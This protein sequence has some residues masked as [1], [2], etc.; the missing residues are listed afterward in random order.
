MAAAPPPFTPNSS[1][2]RDIDFGVISEAF[3]LLTANWQTY[4]TAGG[5]S[6]LALLPSVVVAYLPMIQ[7][8]MGGKPDPTAVFATLGLQLV[9][10]F[11]GVL[12]A[13]FISVGVVKHTLN[14]TRGLPAS[15]G[16]IFEGFRDPL[17]YFAVMFLAG[18]VG[19]L[20]VIA[21]CIGALFTAGLVMFALPHKVATGET[22][23][24]SI[25]KSWEMLKSNWPMAGIFLLVVS[26]IAQ[27]G[28]I[29]CYIGLVFTM[30]FQYIATTLLYNR[31]VGW[32]PQVMYNPASPYPR[33]QG[34]GYD[35]GAGAPPSE[36]P[37]EPPKPSDMG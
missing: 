35:I 34:P 17:G 4:V 28:A 13:M 6:M 2:R 33:G 23:T 1:P 27:A 8:A 37:H 26:M 32:A 24:Q 20:G 21:C 31:F 12:V 16:D 30:P 25:S 11:A 29:A 14:L 10:E 36:K 9:L 5:I 19:A 15:T 3:S 22:A 7:Q 18:L